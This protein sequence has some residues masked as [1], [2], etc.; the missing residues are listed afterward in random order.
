MIQVIINIVKPTSNINMYKVIGNN[1]SYLL[2]DGIQL[3]KKG[4]K[5]LSIEILRHIYKIYKWT[6]KN[7]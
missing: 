2:S 7:I 5:S 6:F 1:P 3:S 4:H